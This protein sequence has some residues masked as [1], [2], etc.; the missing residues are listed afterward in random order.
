MKTT[1]EKKTFTGLTIGQITWAF[2]S[3]CFCSTQVDHFLEKSIFSRTDHQDS[4]RLTLGGAF[5]DILKDRSF[6]TRL[7]S[8]HYIGSYQVYTVRQIIHKCWHFSFLLRLNQGSKQSGQTLIMKRKKDYTSLCLCMEVK[9]RS[10]LQGCQGADKEP[11]A[12]RLT[13]EALHELLFL[14]KTSF[15]FSTSPP[16]PPCYQQRQMKWEMTE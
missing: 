13:S 12:C 4:A 9:S 2:H 7:Q 14:L 11:V 1:K 8:I 3:V 16:T 10:R 15:L 5:K 6:F